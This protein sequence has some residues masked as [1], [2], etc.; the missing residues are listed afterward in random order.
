MMENEYIRNL[1]EKTIQFLFC[2]HCFVV[3][4]WWLCCRI[5]CYSYYN[6]CRTICQVGASCIPE[7]QGTNRHNIDNKN[8]FIKCHNVQMLQKEVMSKLRCLCLVLYFPIDL[9]PLSFNSCFD[10]GMQPIEFNRWVYII[11]CNWFSSYS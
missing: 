7:K 1:W 8:I 4:H 11:G 6:L 5:L 9:L 10:L 3:A 2:F